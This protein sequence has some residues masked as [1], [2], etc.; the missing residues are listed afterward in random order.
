MAQPG[1]I[2]VCGGGECKLTHNSNE[3]EEDDSAGKLY[4]NQEKLTFVLRVS[5]TSDVCYRL[6]RDMMDKS[7]YF[8]LLTTALSTRK[9]L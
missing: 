9:C 1:G 8:L 5:L 7:N 4:S 2:S 6:L 3:C